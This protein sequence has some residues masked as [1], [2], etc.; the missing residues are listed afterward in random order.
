MVSVQSA[1][2][3]KQPRAEWVA[4][5][6]CRDQGLTDIFYVR[7]GEKVFA[8][9]EYCA[10]C[11][12]RKECLQYAIDN[13]IDHGIWGGLSTRARHDPQRVNMEVERPA[14]ARIIEMWEAGWRQR[15]IG[16]E[17]GVSESHVAGVLHRFRKARR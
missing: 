12:V 14:T 13:N 7:P 9:L 16:R 10:R 11:P 8:A 3:L 1:E 2:F 15:A 4:R 5:A 6:A 17:L